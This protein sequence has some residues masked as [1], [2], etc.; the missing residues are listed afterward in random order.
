[1][2]IIEWFGKVFSRSPTDRTIDISEYRSELQNNIA[3]EAFAL[4][5][6]IDMIASLVAKCEFKTYRNGKEYKGYEWYSLNV[7][8]N[9]NQNSTEFWQEFVSKLLFYREVLVI[10]VNNQLIIADDF[11]KEEFAVKETEFTQ[12]SRGDMT[13]NRKYKMSD[14]LYVKYSNSNAMQIFN[15][16]FGMYEKLIDSASDKY[17]RAGGQKG[18]LDIP[19]IAQNEK[20]FEKKYQKLMNEYFNSYFKSKNAVLPLW[21]GMKYTPTTSDSVK[22]TT[23]EIADI[24]RLVDDALSRAAQAYKVQPALVRGDV[25]GIKDAVDMTLTTCI[26]P[27][28]DMISEELTGK[29]YMPEEVM[30]GSYIAG[31]TTCIKHIDIFD[32]APN[33]DK[34]ISS[35]MLNIDETREKA[36]LVP[37]GEKWAQ[38]H[39]ITK[40]YTTTQGGEVNENEQTGNDDEMQP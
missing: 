9:K 39:Y 5:T 12:V 29:K 15:S 11:N 14:V 16:I 1:M 24:S 34:L 37:T 40:N 7:K 28:V 18:T 20:D 19:A 4:F 36:G 25:A 17:I 2:R 13:F 31:D 30:K 22:K 38:Q 10:N 6:T 32:I 27:L 3:L 23:S 8:P 35:G 21:G 33:A 26:D